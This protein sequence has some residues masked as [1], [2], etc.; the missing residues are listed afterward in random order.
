MKTKLVQFILCLCFFVSTQCLAQVTGVKY[1]MNYNVEESTMDCYLLI[2]GGSATTQSDRTQFNAVWTIV[3]PTKTKLSIK[4]KFNPKTSNGMPMDWVI[5]TKILA[6]QVTPN[7][8]Y[9]V[10]APTLAPV[11]RYD[12]LNTGVTVKLFSLAID[13]LAGCLSDIRLFDNNSDP[14]SDAPGLL[15]ADLSNGFTVGNIDQIYQGNTTTPPSTLVG[16]DRTTCAGSTITLDP[17]PNKIGTWHLVNNA[18]TTGIV[19]TNLPNSSATISFPQVVKS[20]L[21]SVVF[22]TAS[23]SYDYLCINIENFISLPKTK[24]CIGE[25]LQVSNPVQGVWE[26]TN[27]VASITPNGEITCLTSGQATFV[28]TPDNLGQCP[29]YFTAPLNVDPKLTVSASK[30]TVCTGES[31]VLAPSTGGFW[32]TDNQVI[33][34]ITPSGLL[35]ALNPGPVGCIYTSTNGCPSDPLT[36]TVLPSPVVFFDPPSIICR[37]NTKQL[38]PST[39]G[40][41]ISNYPVTASITSSGL[42]TGL[43]QGLVNFTFTSTGSGCRA[44]TTNL[45]VDEQPT[46]A[47][48]RDTICIGNTTMLQPNSGGTW[49]ALNSSIATLSNGAIVTG[50]AAGEAKFRYTQGQS[51]CESVLTV[52]VRARPV[53]SIDKQSICVGGTALLSPSTG[54]TWS[55]DP[56]VIAAVSNSGVVTGLNPG[57]AAFT[58]TSSVTGC[59]S[60]P[61]P[62][63]SVSTKP[64]VSLNGPN[65]ICIGDQRQLLPSTGGKWVS[66]NPLVAFVTQDGRITAMSEGLASFTFTQNGSGCPAN[67]QNLSVKKLPQ[68]NF[69][70]AAKMCVNSTLALTA[71]V[72]GVWSASA[73]PLVASISPSGL[74][75]GVSP[76]IASFKITDLNGCVSEPLNIEVLPERTVYNVSNLDTICVGS[77]SQLIYCNEQTENWISENPD[78]ASISNDGLIY[79]IKK[80]TTRFYK[81]DD[82]GVQSNSVTI[83]VIDT[84]FARVD[85][86]EDICIGT[87][88]KLHPST[89]GTW[90]SQNV[91]VAT[92]TPSGLVT[93]VSLGTAMFD[94]I[95]STGCKV[96]PPPPVTV[97]PGRPIKSEKGFELC[98]G[99]EVQLRTEGMGIYESDNPSIATIDASTGVFTALSNGT[100][101]ITYT[102]TVLGGVPIGCKSTQ[103]FT[104]GNGPSPA[105]SKYTLCED[106]EIEIPMNNGTF[107]TLNPAVIAVEGNVLVAKKPGI[108]QILYVE[109]GSEC[110]SIINFVVN[111]KAVITGTGLDELCVGSGAYLSANTLGTWINNNDTIFFIDGNNLG[112]DLITIK[113]GTGTVTFVPSNGCQSVITPIVV[114][115][116]IPAELYFDRHIYIS[117]GQEFTAE[118]FASNDIIIIAVPLQ[119]PNITGQKS[120][121]DFYSFTIND[122]LTKS[123]QGAAVAKYLITAEEN[124]CKVTDTLFVHI[125]DRDFNKKLTYCLYADHDR[126]NTYNADSDDL[127]KNIPIK[128]GSLNLTK[129]TN[130]NGSTFFKLDTSKYIVTIN[131][132]AGDWEQPTYVDTVQLDNPDTKI[133]L[134]FKTKQHPPLAQASFSSNPFRCDTHIQIFPSATNIGNANI[135]G[136]L[137]LK[138]SL[139]VN[140]INSNKPY[141]RIS[142]REISWPITSLGISQTFAPG[143]VA[144]MP[145]A[146]GNNDSLQ[147]EVFVLTNEGDTLSQVRYSDVVSCSFDPNDKRSWPDRVGDLNY[148]LRE[149]ELTY[150]IRFQN[151]GNDTAYSVRIVDVLDSNLDMRSLRILNS[152]HDVATEIFGDTLVFNFDNINLVDSLTNPL[153]SQGFVSFMI[154]EYTDIPDLTALYNTVAIYFDKNE[155]VITNTARNTI[156]NNLPCPSNAIFVEGDAIRVNQAQSTYRWYDCLTDTLIAT[157]SEPFYKPTKNGSYYAGIE[158]EFCAVRTNCVSFTLVST[159]ENPQPIIKISPNPASDKVTIS[160]DQEITNIQISDV[161]GKVVRSYEVDRQNEI[162][163]DIQTISVGTYLIQITTDSG[164]IASKVVVQE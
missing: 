42:V 140:I 114:I 143:L 111:T 80:G 6:P 116:T 150:Q 72:Q 97:Q 59:I 99:T 147:F 19:L 90:T 108:G 154:D 74:I 18:D 71:D 155:P 63:L 22:K 75:T 126:N 132:P 61:S 51:G 76:G 139:R 32:S 117:N 104:I 121:Q 12:N 33:G 118:I 28:F 31:V 57:N 83:H 73:G 27:G 29:F 69:G 4:Q 8:D 102:E 156:V 17:L 164:S 125:D 137:I 26:S 88:T 50:V 67:T 144:L 21:Y 52:Q 93:G 40:V 119:N 106:E 64:I 152:S 48:N 109:T 157:T 96:V 49:T 92:T 160:C 79:M 89:D 136:K 161:T 95:P 128:I 120:Y 30:T 13:T 9:Y 68:I 37:G 45:I 138:H 123:N 86:R 141:T 5:A 153:L 134:G 7:F 112:V 91:A 70:G 84:V 43:Q 38:Q 65:T 94:F 113:E 24:A 159:E 11:G 129:L 3:V 146:M 25:K 55:S 131:L 15:G 107:T 103:E 124:G 105:F 127:L 133:T 98:I 122:I 81:I 58:Y 20:G 85:G 145:S 149:E 100:V 101:T 39:G 115:N 34:S 47:A 77:S 78:I 151:T 2:A 158:G 66:N 35:T 135:K 110:R 1:M 14:K 41:W 130:A 53:V 87:T 162:T 163:L 62:T 60:L 16:N 10:I 142:D 54:G 82:L 56:T 148:T 23:S 44:T 46:V 36:I